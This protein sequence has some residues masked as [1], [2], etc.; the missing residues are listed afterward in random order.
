VAAPPSRNFS[1]IDIWLRL[2]HHKVMHWTLA[3]AAASY[4]LLHGVEMVSNSLSWPHIIARML[5]LVLI[6][7]VPV[8]MTLA[9]YHGAKGLQKVSVPELA[10]ITLLG[11]I[12]G[13]ILWSM[14]PSGVDHESGVRV[15]TDANTAAV[16][17]AAT[18][19]AF[20]RTAVAVLPFTNLTGDVNKEYLGDGMAEELIN[21]LTKVQNLKVPARTSTFAY[22]GRNTDIR[23]IAKDLGVGTILEGSVRAAGKRIRITAQLINAQDGLHLWSETYDRDFTDVFKLQDDLANAIA[24]ALQPSLTGAKLPIVT[25]ARPTQDVEAYRLY[26]LG[27]SLSSRP[28][29]ENL[30]RATEYFQQAIARDP[31]FGRAYAGLAE[32]YLKRDNAGPEMEKAARKA[33]ELDP[34][35]AP[36]HSE[37][38]WLASIAGHWLEE[39]SESRAALAADATDGETHVHYAE[40]LLKVGHVGR[41]LRETEQAYALAPA[42]P[43]VLMSLA[44]QYLAVGRDAEAVKYAD[45]AAE[46]GVPKSILVVV[47]AGVARRAGRFNEAADILINSPGPDDVHRRR[48]NEVARRVYAALAEPAKKSVAVA[49]VARLYPRTG[50]PAIT[51]IYHA[52]FC[53]EGSRHNALLGAL[54]A[55]FEIANRC[56]DDMAAAGL[57]TMGLVSQFFWSPEM[58]PFRQDPRFQ[59]YATRLGLMEFWQQNGPPD[60]CDLSNGTLTCH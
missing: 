58:R 54:D 32:V 52:T 38:A 9:W 4:T 43:N 24:K 2:Q 17:A 59:A 6:L 50:A 31:A 57:R 42:S 10:I 22:K 55:A 35:I 46:L 13:T 16:P 12:A 39:D 11:I 45:Q 36:A 34:A 53:T 29:E 8:V 27:S 37:L 18:T 49:A 33:I 47:Y 56:L 15:E 23:Q 1:L 3:Y 7:G 60:D 21:T 30:L 20:P 40:M 19:A 41:A 48:I 28:S 26:L 14:S 44:N 51:T 25:P 5:T